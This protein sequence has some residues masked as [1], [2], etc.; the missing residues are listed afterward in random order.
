MAFTNFTKP[1]KR[2]EP[3]MAEKH[4][5]SVPMVLNRN[6]TLAST[7]GHI[8]NF[9][10]GK[11]VYVPYILIREAANMGAET[12]DG[13]DPRAEPE[14]KKAPQPVDPG[15]RLE[16]IDKVVGEMLEENAR[17]DFTASGN[18]KVSSVSERVGFK[19]DGA[20]VRTVIKDRALAAENES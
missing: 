15:A 12:V 8:I 14:S 20:E 18:P 10:K 19:V 7:L 6:A 2:K 4:G 11:V 5:T 16:A 17:D 3:I 13:T 1:I 9:K